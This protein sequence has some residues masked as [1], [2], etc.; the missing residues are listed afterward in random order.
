MKV[1]KLT[2]MYN[3]RK[4]SEFLAVGFKFGEVS[5]RV[6]TTVHLDKVTNI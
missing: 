3:G 2:I 5:F 4:F 6:Q 1:R